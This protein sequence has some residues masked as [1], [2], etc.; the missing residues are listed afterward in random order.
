MRHAIGWVVAV[1]AVIIGATMVARVGGGPNAG[2]ANEP[3]VF[4]P[5]PASTFQSA[6]RQLPADTAR[7]RA[8]LQAARGTNAV[9]CELAARTVDGR[10]GWSSDDMLTAR[11]T[12]DSAAGDVVEW[13]HDREISAATVPLLRA[14]IGDSDWCVRRI[15]A[16]ILGRVHDPSATQAMLA[17]LA[18]PE[19]GT[20]EMGA[21]ALGFAGDTHT[22]A[23]LVARLRDESPRVRATAAWALGEMESKAAVRPLIGVLKDADASA[24]ESAAHALGEVKDTAGIIPLTDVLKSDREPA[25]RRAA[26]RALGEISG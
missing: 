15:A 18:A 17:A 23:P 8:L 19:A 21:L 5:L 3:W 4:V 10:S 12:A 6:A 16:P 26:A 25:V 2:A 13:V 20:R 7:V 22:V 14:A 24:R 11:G 9:V 1:P